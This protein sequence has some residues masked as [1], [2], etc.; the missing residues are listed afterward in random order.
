MRVRLEVEFETSA[1]TVGQAVDFAAE[2][3]AAGVLSLH[4]AECVVIDDR[5]VERRAVSPS[6]SERVARAEERM[7]SS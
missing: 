6:F 3:V 2:T 5:L 4:D 7:A 1:R